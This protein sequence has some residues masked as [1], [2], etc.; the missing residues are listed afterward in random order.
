MKILGVNI[1][2]NA[3]IC[4]VTD[5]V[6]DFYLEEDRFNKIKNYCPSPKE[7][8]KFKSIT[9]YVDDVYDEIIF[10]SYD[11]TLPF[12]EDS[13]LEIGRAHV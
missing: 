7:Q 9:E 5:G 10:S 2:H 12:R 3:S 8:T 6:I 4:Q 13:K 11:R 1:S